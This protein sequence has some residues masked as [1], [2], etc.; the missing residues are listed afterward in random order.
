M[1]KIIQKINQLIPQLQRDAEKIR[2]P[3]AAALLASVAMDL[4]Q[5]I[6]YLRI[7]SGP[8][9]LDYVVSNF[10]AMI[11]NLEDGRNGMNPIDKTYLGNVSHQLRGIIRGIMDAFPTEIC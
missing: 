11:N 10:N 3:R 7:I 6:N 4:A 5:S 8:D 9:T 2:N 1:N